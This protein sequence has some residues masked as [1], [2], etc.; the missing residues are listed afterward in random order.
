MSL[1]QAK[2]PIEHPLK[3]FEGTYVGL[4]PTDESDIG[5]G[6]ISITISGESV[7]WHYA[8]GLEIQ[9]HDNEPSEFRE[10][11]PAEIAALLPEV[12]EGITVRVFEAGI[13][14]YIFASSP[15]E[16]EAPELLIVGGMGDIL[17]PTMLFSPAQVE[18]GI[19]EKVFKVIEEE[20][21]E[22]GDMPRLANGGLAPNDHQS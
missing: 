7:S 1:E 13:H 20:M 19:H 18:Q 4:G 5:V 6:E 15:S 8:T 21:G 22:A 11:P 2:T 10:L 12:E 9:L 17:G 14:K 3:D 16:P